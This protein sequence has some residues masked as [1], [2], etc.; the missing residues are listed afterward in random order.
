L[1]KIRLLSCLIIFTLLFTTFDLS[2][3]SA[4]S[5]NEKR[6]Y[7]VKFINERSINEQLLEKQVLKRF[8]YNKLVLAELSDNERV[9]LI[10]SGTIEYIEADESIEISIPT[11][12]EL[13][14]YNVAPDSDQ[15]ELDTEDSN[16][17]VKIAVLDTGINALSQLNVTGG[18]SFVPGTDFT[19]DHGHGTYI[20][21][22]ITGKAPKLES[23]TKLYS[24]KVLDKQGRG[25]YSQIIEAVEWAIDNQMNI[26]Y[27][28]FGGPIYSQPMSE[29]MN[30]A[31]ERGLLL[32]A[33]AGDEGRNTLQ[34]PAKFNTVLAV[35]A[36]D[37]NREQLPASHTG[38]ELD[39]VAQGTQIKG[40]GKDGEITII[41]GTATA[42]AQVSYTAA[43]Y[44]KKFP[45]LD[46]PTIIELLKSNAKPLGEFEKYGY[47]LVQYQLEDQESTETQPDTPKNDVVEPNEQ[48]LEVDNNELLPLFKGSEEEIQ[49]QK[50]L[51]LR[52]KQLE[53]GENVN[54]LG[55]LRLNTEHKQ[56]EL[57]RLLQ[58]EKQLLE[59]D[60]SK[61]TILDLVE[62]FGVTDDWI[63]KQKE[64][65]FTLQNIFTLLWNQREKGGTNNRLTASLLKQVEI[66]IPMQSI[67]S[68]SSA[69]S[70]LETMNPGIDRASIIKGYDQS[71]Q[72][73]LDLTFGY[74]ELNEQK[75]Q[76][77]E[78]PT[79][80]KELLDPISDDFAEEV[81]EKTK[82][83]NHNFKSLSMAKLQNPEEM[84]LIPTIKLSEAPYKVGLHQENVS[85]ISGSLSLAET[86]L[87]LPGRNG[88]SFS[89]QRTYNSS[90]AQKFDMDLGNT[91]TY[92][93][94]FNYRYALMSQDI[95]YNLQRKYSV[96][97]RKYSCSTGAELWSG[98]LDPETFSGGTYK[99]ELALDNARSNPP[100]L[101]SVTVHACGSRPAE[102]DR[103]YVNSYTFHSNSWSEQL[104]PMQFLYFNQTDGPFSN[105]SGAQQAKT[106]MDGGA[107]D[108]YGR[109]G[110]YAGGY[111]TYGLVH[112]S[113]SGTYPSLIGRSY[114]NTVKD[115]KT[116]KMFP[117]GKGWTWNI[118]Y[119]KFEN[120]QKYVSYDGG[121][122]EVQGS[123]LKN[124]PWSD[125][126]LESDTSVT[127]DGKQSA[128]A[129]KSVF[130]SKQY[131]DASGNI[132]QIKDV[133]NNWIGFKYSIV[134]PYGTVL[135][136]IEDVIGNAI[137][138]QYT[139]NQVTL[140]HGDRIV[141]YHKATL[142][143]KE[144]LSK[145][146]D[147]MGRQTTYSYNVRP[148]SFSLV[149]QSSAQNNPF[150]L[151]TEVVHPT[152]AK[153]VYTYE[154][155]PV[156]RRIEENQYNQAYRVASRED[157]L[158]Y[159]NQTTE[160]FN[161]STIVYTGDM[162]SNFNQSYTFATTLFDGLLETKMSYKKNFVDSSI[163]SQYYNTQIKVSDGTISS[164]TDLTYDEIKHRMSPV[165]TSK[166]YKN[167]LTQAS[168]IPVTEAMVYDDYQN[169]LSYK[170]PLGAIS[171]FTFN[172]TTHLLESSVQPV[173]ESNSV[174]TEVVSRNLQGD[175]TEQ[176][177]RDSSV[178]GNILQHIQKT[179]DSYGNITLI[180]SNDVD[181]IRDTQIEYS[182]IYKFAYPTT[183]TRPNT[184]VNGHAQI[185]E[186]TYKLTTGELESL[187]KGNQNTFFM[188]DRL[189]R[190]IETEHPDGTKISLN[191]NDTLNE[192]KQTDEVGRITYNKWNTLGWL[193]GLGI[194]ESGIVK[195]ISQTGYDSFGRV[196]WVEDALSNQT[197]LTYDNWGRVLTTKLSNQ[198]IANNA[199]DDLAFTVT[200]TDASNN[201]IRQT[202]DRFGRV[203]KKEEKYNDAFRYIWTGSYD[204]GNHLRSE[205]DGK[206]QITQY[207][208]NPSGNLIRVKGANQQ[209]YSYAYNRAGMLTQVTY[210]DQSL[211]FKTY[212]D[213]GQLIQTTDPMQQK[214][215]FSYDENGNLLTFTNK[216]NQL[217][218]YSYNNR[219]FLLSKSGPTDT[220]SY[221]Y[222]PDGSRK[223]MKDNGN[224]TTT[225]TYNPFIAQLEKV[226]NPDG[227]SIT[228]SYDIVGN[229]DITTLPFNDVL[230][231][232]FYDVNLLKSVKW[233]GSEQA[234]YTYNANGQ[235][236]DFTQAN[237]M[238]TKYNYINGKLSKLEHK[239]NA[240]AVQSYEYKYDVNG[241][242]EDRKQTKS[243]VT[244]SDYFT[245]DSMN[246]ISTS[247][248][249]DES[250]TYDNRGNR[251]N[252]YSE[253]PALMP[254]E[255]SY[256]Y[257]EWDRLTKVTRG[258]SVV[259][260]RYNGDNLLIERKENNITNRYYY[261]GDHIIA[262][263]I[264]QPNGS[265]TK[266]ASYIYGNDLI[267]REDAGQTKAFYLKNG[268]GDIVSMR[269]AA[270]SV[271]N[272]YEYDIWGNTIEETGTTPNPFRYSGE[273]WDKTVKLQ[274]LRARWYDPGMGRFI[275]QDTY[276][277]ELTNPLSQNLYT[278]VHNNPLIYIDPSGHK[279][280]LIH[281][282]NLSGTETPEAT[283][284]SDFIKYIGDLYKED[285]DTPRWSGG[286][287][288]SAR[289]D[290]ADAIAA[291]IIK[292]RK[293]N[294]DEPIRLVG[295]SHG[296]NVA[297]M[298]ANLLGD[299]DIKVETLVTIATPVRGYKLEQ[300]VGQHLHVYNERDGIQ[301]NGGSIWLLG[302]ARRTF[303]DAANVKVEV[304]K[305]Y[306]G[307][308]SHSVMHSNVS[309][310]EKYI[311][312]LLADFYVKP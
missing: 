218:T 20:A 8:K 247:T 81:N 213:L 22:I 109:G 189:G 132:I 89:L 105:E 302:K 175:I 303:K 225:Y 160:S 268:H 42:A 241:N 219:N 40:Y 204:I 71:G 174:Y 255:V 102:P 24:L 131:F 136:S 208:Y 291:E 119:M 95:S 301:I 260:Y 51:Y 278:Y 114:Y 112:W 216:K 240:L 246:R 308:E 45:N 206:N 151:L 203:I 277:G 215:K 134:N 107:N 117:I 58:E 70:K 80:Q 63:I 94:F 53:L 275:N 249:F 230:D 263:G 192:L 2:V 200:S 266:T 299:E 73:A 229:R 298:V 310:W 274:Y 152:G 309:V 250:Y 185:T 130:G 47:G 183:I 150:T 252:L 276:E 265:V 139:T 68:S 231:Y 93:Y 297:I 210:P 217:F 245:Y 234:S 106:A 19:D 261:D 43:K 91:D 135:T 65:G 88:L 170:S 307:V 26:V 48:D 253:N 64:A 287:K 52:M 269:N 113:I 284:T 197:L 228:Y 184:A 30:T 207:S 212:D 141:V 38:N 295:H 3:F 27:M 292:W 214:E 167:E 176:K 5:T 264:V 221:T 293:E 69:E 190:L 36:V 179:Y 142:D 248:L 201:S 235:L 61:L 13:A 163:G 281:G 239:Q 129:L 115:K 271:L 256:V 244:K 300:E 158:V 191:I 96:T 110:S 153:S 181:K 35:G 76:P 23:G 12:Q 157:V 116:D 111:Y 120:G 1:K 41:E 103:K 154:V 222:Y 262:E 84:P 85:L 237:G 273:Y 283:W 194:V 87:T 128:Y 147:P 198:S 49:L 25:T 144:V 44:M 312:G 180:R 172:G 98:A 90:D 66:G 31:Y 72:V 101:S 50:M 77:T 127:Y 232:D 306:D 108:Q 304:D 199:Y 272:Q 195:L 211:S 33:P 79:E 159:S 223:T 193:T 156:T 86:D 296:G 55:E 82:E 74:T 233:N 4:T 99:T 202:S 21:S 54:E 165:S 118:P 148:A 67:N 226:I 242:I 168:T 6:S 173:D 46:A 60:L 251:K 83:T 186:G 205:Q 125:L 254:E 32:I 257:D 146:V 39:L 123:S 138:I 188:Y 78:Q 182:S 97:T 220:I 236:N 37:L 145:V 18:A 282:T 311:K 258:G 17:E 259:E 286:N 122:Y 224:Q 267:M 143:G 243:N 133:Y 92:G 59:S 171:V 9:Q 7:M 169:M 162:S 270:G 14:K 166:Y 288:N 161:R 57:K 124:Y 137:T 196:N 29:I 34:F 126:S 28:S 155:N 280:W 294:P 178:T 62:E 10:Q 187:K 227:K 164:V 285:V 121:M 16:A 104:E 290:A 75:E 238:V 305:K 279:I 209:T 11:K 100:S 177:L 140:T 15:M 289:S 56:M 149:D